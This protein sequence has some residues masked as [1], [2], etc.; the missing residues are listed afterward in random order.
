M[1]PQTI[2]LGVLLSWTALGC[3]EDAESPAAPTMA[4]ASAAA[5]PLFHQFAASGFQSCGVATDG[6]GW[7]WG[8][9][10]SGQLGNG[11]FDGPEIAPVEVV[12]DLS[13]RQINTD[14]DH[15]CGVTTD[16][17]AYCWGGNYTGQLG[18][19]TVETRAVPTPVAGGLRFYNINAGQLHT[20]GVS[21]PDR[22]GYCWG[23]NANGQL[24]DATLEERWVPTLVSGGLRFRTLTAG[25]AYTCGVTVDDEAYCWGS[26]QFGQLGDGSQVAQRKRP[27]PVSGGLAFVQ[28]EAGTAHTCGI[29]RNSRAYCWGY[30]RRGQLGDGSMAIR[31]T[32]RAVA[33][34]LTFRRVAPGSGFTCAERA[35][36]AVYCWG[37]NEF[38]Q[39]GDGTLTRRLKPVPLKSGLR[40]GQVGAGGWNACGKT[41]ENVGY[42]WGLNDAGQL[43]DGT[44]QD[45][46]TPVRVAP[47]GTVALQAAVGPRR[48]KVPVRADT[49]ASLD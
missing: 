26:N 38:G 5:A 13:F 34:G 9:N 36:N 30:G 32:P 19:G 12:G 27:G 49:L 44:T 33:G 42:C 31:R 35:T 11:S 20:C 2:A 21:Y 17:H 29:T 23:H 10:Y 43:G 25:A 28:V 4:L 15:T 3:R 40:F 22:K 16:F 6:P 14:N 39:L 37:S 18:D 45:R 48:V 24:G 41:T 1:R 7:C 8:S 47:P 46:H